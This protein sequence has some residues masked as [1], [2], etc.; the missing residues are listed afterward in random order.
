[1]LAASFRGKS[2]K[3]FKL[4]PLRL[5]AK[6]EHKPLRVMLLFSHAKR[7]REMWASQ[8][9]KGREK[10]R[11]RWIDRE[12]GGGVKARERERQREKERER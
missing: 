4:F 9:E 1:M 12:R 7:E 3:R 2:L 6:L 10:E 8:G 11:K 5:E